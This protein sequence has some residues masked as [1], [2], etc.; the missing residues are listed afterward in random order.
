M[1]PGRNS[2]TQSDPLLCIHDGAAADVAARCV[3]VSGVPATHS[4]THAKACHPVAPS[5]VQLSHCKPHCRKNQ[6]A[7][8][9]GGRSWQCLQ[10][11]TNTAHYLGPVL[12]SQSESAS[13]LPSV[14]PILTYGGSRSSLLP[15][16]CCQAP[17]PKA[18]TQLQVENTTQQTTG[19][20]VDPGQQQR[21]L[22]CEFGP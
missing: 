20:Q 2:W 4:P 18:Q 11:Q 8:G 21:S 14:Q 5:I 3:V 13:E 10:L 16:A 15:E 22:Q 9:G 1:C 12:P 19:G 6:R 7:Y 17:M